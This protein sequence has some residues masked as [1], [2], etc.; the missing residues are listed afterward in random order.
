MLKTTVLYVEDDLVNQR[1]IQRIVT[2]F[3]YDFASAVD[4]AEAVQAAHRYHP[5]V[6][7]LDINL[8]SGEAMD[9][10]EKLNLD[11]ILA[12]TPKII[13]SADDRQTQKMRYLNAGCT[14][15]LT[16]PI[17]AMQLLRSIDRAM[18]IAH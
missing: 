14:D 17:N 18:G 9:V 3:G 6:I 13:V 8:I 12:N 2:G 4:C 11:P 15:Y 1:L 7:L 16:K 5:F 10:I